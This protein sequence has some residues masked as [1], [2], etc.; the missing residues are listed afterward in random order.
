MIG[1][2]LPNN[3]ENSYSAILQ[4]IL[5][6]NQPYVQTQRSGN[7]SENWVVDEPAQHGSD[8]THR[9]FARWKNEIL[10]CS[11]RGFDPGVRMSYRNRCLRT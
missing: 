1:Q 11:D 3:I 9:P 6:L 2:Y 7:G 5:H 4:K 10:V 8:A